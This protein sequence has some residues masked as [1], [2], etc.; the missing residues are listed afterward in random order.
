MSEDV[1]YELEEALEGIGSVV[2]ANSVTSLFTLAA[3]VLGAIALFTMAKRR[4]IH[5]AWLS[6][7]PV[8]NNWILGSLADQYRYVSR[9]EVKNKRKAML[10]LSIIQIVMNMIF[11][12]AIIGFVIKLVLG[13]MNSATEDEMFTAIAGLVLGMLA[14]CIPLA[15][16][17][18]AHMIIR[19]MALYDVYQS[20]APENSTM[21]LVL[22]IFFR[23][24]EPFFLFFNREKDTGMVLK[25]QNQSSSQIPSYVSTPENGGTWSEPQQPQQNPPAPEQPRQA[26]QNP[27]GSPEPW[28]QKPENQDPWNQGPEQL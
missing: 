28:N 3:Y 13:G 1:M 17:A 20:C 18:I 8:G 7:I 6:W 25:N 12:G 26:Q 14:L 11:F 21:F 2:A 22:S 9:R 16:V 23:I 10:T 5:H 15:G 27:E 24:T 4:G 19:F